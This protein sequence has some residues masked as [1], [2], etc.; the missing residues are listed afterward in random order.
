MAK[1]SFAKVL[2]QG[3]L[4][5]AG[6]SQT[7]KSK[8]PGGIKEDLGIDMEVLI[9]E[10]ESLDAQQEK[11]KAELKT[12][13]EELERTRKKF[14]KIYADT[15]KRVKLDVPKTQWLAYGIEDKI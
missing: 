2:L 9:K 14:E 8:L 1:E 11:L 10:L 4:M 15:K 12:K 6:L 7:A 13:T 5:V 3:K